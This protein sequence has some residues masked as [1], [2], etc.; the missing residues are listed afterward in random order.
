MV[1]SGKMTLW[2]SH[3]SLLWDAKLLAVLCQTQELAGCNN[4]IRLFMDL[5]CSVFYLLISMELFS[6]CPPGGS[7]WFGSAAALM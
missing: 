3:S 1:K 4:K 7:L 2:H 6:G 5:C